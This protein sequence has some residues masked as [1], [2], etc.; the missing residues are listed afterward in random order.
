LKLVPNLPVK[1]LVQRFRSR[2]VKPNHL[3]CYNRTPTPSLRTGFPVSHGDCA[4]FLLL[5]F[6]L[7]RAFSRAAW[8][9][10]ETGLS[11]R[12]ELALVP[13]IQT[14]EICSSKKETS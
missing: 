5:T 2:P 6:P 10:A 1:L 13:S 7:V 9:Q 12:H 11:Q 3:K 14:P 4:G 8:E